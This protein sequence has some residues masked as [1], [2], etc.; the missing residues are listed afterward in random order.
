MSFQYLWAKECDNLMAVAAMTALAT[1]TLSSSDTEVLFQN[2]PQDYRDLMLIYVASGSGDENMTPKFNGSA[3]D[4]SW[5]Q[6]TTGGS[7]NAGTNNSIGRVANASS[8]G[9]LE[10]FDYSATDK[11]KAF[12]VTT[13]V[14]G[15]ERR[16]LAARWA[17]TTAISSLSVSIRTG[18]SFDTGGYFSL[19]GIE[20]II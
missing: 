2:I 5:V 3:A 6:M 13:N 8:L 18:Y 7:G 9:K 20:G 4:F 14:T 15:S 10:I 12:T 11:H 19:W 1:V 17:Q 16:V